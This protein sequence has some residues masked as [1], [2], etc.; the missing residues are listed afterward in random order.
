MRH[1]KSNQMKHSE[2]DKVLVLK[3]DALVTAFG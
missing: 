3:M 2:H 1:D